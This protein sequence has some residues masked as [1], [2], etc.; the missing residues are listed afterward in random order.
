MYHNWKLSANNGNRFLT[1]L[2]MQG[3]PFILTSGNIASSPFSLSMKQPD[4][5]KVS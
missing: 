1:Y 3:F 2:K 5:G 4:F